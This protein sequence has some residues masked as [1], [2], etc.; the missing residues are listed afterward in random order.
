MV[1]HF[2][3]RLPAHFILCMIKQMSSENNRE[4]HVL[5]HDFPFMFYWNNGH[6]PF[7]IK[8]LKKK[9]KF[10]EITGTVII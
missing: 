8:Q 4:K 2:F 3:N 6:H 9:L 10:P 5:F 1:S 7:M